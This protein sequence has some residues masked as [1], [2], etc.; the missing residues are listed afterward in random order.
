M[1]Q[2]KF[3][4]RMK[5]GMHS[6]E[7][8]SASHCIPSADISAKMMIRSN[9][10]DLQKG[11]GKAYTMCHIHCGYHHFPYQT[12]ARVLKFVPRVSL[13]LVLQLFLEMA[14]EFPVLEI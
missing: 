6:R 11:G 12:S 9:I 10:P 1:I 8:D 3:T 7:C 14:K 13:H 5:Q 4:L 2:I